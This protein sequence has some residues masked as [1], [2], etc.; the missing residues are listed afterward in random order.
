[1]K[2]L[3]VITILG[4]VLGFSNSSFASNYMGLYINGSTVE[5]VKSE[6]RGGE[7]ETNPMSFYVSPVINKTDS[8]IITET[9]QNDENALLVFGIRI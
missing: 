9:A 7:I 2:K 3:T 6:V 1:M 5:E 4:L 8:D